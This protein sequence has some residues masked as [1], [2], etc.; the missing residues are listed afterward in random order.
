MTLT[1]G[2]VRADGTEMQL[3]VNRK[4]QGLLCQKEICDL[5]GIALRTLHK[6]RKRWGLRPVEFDGLM[7][8]FDPQDVERAD[9]RRRKTRLAQ[10]S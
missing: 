2:N 9:E 4:R 3:T 8:L 5:W 7:P 10:L 6:E 1:D